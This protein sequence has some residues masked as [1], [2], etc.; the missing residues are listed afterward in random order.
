MWFRR[1]VS[2][3]CNKRSERNVHHAMQGE[4]AAYV[5]VL[6]M[7]AVLVKISSFNYVVLDTISWV[8]HWDVE[9]CLIMSCLMYIFNMC[10]ILDTAFL[11]FINTWLY[12]NFSI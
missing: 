10:T 8:T 7:Y 4:V 6:H 11:F 12:K 3:L 2:R 5:Y 1:Y 9:L